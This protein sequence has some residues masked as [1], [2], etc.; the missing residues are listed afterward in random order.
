MALLYCLYYPPPLLLTTH[1]DSLLLASLN[2]VCL[3]SSHLYPTSVSEN[4]LKEVSFN[5]KF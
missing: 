1:L 2:S 5:S 3:K 4:M